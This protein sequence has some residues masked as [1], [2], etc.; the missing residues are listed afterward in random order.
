[1]VMIRQ[2]TAER[3]FACLLCLVLLASC[4]ILPAFAAEEGEETAPAVMTPN[5]SVTAPP[6]E[7]EKVETQDEKEENGDEN[8]GFSIVIRPGSE[9]DVVENNK[10]VFVG[11]V[12][13]DENGKIYYATQ[14]GSGDWTQLF[15]G[16]IGTIGTVTTVEKTPKIV[17]VLA[18]AVAVCLCVIVVL[19]V[20]LVKKKKTR[21]RTA[22]EMA[23]ESKSKYVG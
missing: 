11:S 5:Y 8:P 18:A 6:A 14:N 23:Y 9:G 15:Q 21:M 16:T 10:V 13:T 17:Y 12:E 4:L 19:V 3:I 7:T 1:M 20:L 2:H 22:A